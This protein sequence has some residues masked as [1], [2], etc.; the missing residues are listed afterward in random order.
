MDRHDSEQ[1]LF[2]AQLAQHGP[3]APP[4]TG[5]LTTARE[6][7]RDLAR[8]HYENFAVTSWLLPRELRPHFHA[9]YAY[10]RWSDD[11]VDEVADPA[12]SRELLDWWEDGLRT[13]LTARQ[14]HP[15]FVALAETIHQYDIPLEPFH[16]LL[17]AFRQDITRTRYATI[18]ELQQ[19][20]R[21]SANPVGRIVLHLYRA[22]S[23]ERAILSNAICTGLQWVNF[24]Q[25][26]SRDWHERGRIYLPRE[27]WSKFGI[28]SEDDFVECVC[29]A[30]KP[31]VRGQARMPDVRIAMRQLVLQETAR[32][33]AWLQE[34]R[35]LVHEL[36]W[37]LGRNL[38]L[39]VQGG[40]AICAK[41]EAA[42]GEVLQSRP[43]VSKWDQ[44]ALLARTWWRWR[45][46]RRPSFSAAANARGM[47]RPSASIFAPAGSEVTR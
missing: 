28:E 31:N 41:I 43:R 46:G 30:G 17:T 8:T 36:P 7:C 34:G 5:D 42:H 16:D 29:Q 1:E 12:R 20:C 25:D 2:S 14:W 11:L 47:E 19:Y 26:V 35:P 44:A 40:L 38:D 23:P 15:V 18:N 22:W 32:A 33:R 10:C 37:S 3:Q 4:F 13:C 9:V 45:G 24:C 21:F 39:M 6:Y 27:S